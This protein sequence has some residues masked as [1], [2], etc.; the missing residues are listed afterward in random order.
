[1]I[2]SERDIRTRKIACLVKMNINFF[3]VGLSLSWFEV[4]LGSSIMKKQNQ[5]RGHFSF[6]VCRQKKK[7]KLYSLFNVYYDKGRSNE[8]S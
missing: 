4:C 8:E 2:N 5:F 7:S 1:M 3:S 6:P